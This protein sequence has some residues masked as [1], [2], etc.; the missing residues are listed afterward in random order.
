M[1]AS[2]AAMFLASKCTCAVYVN[3]HVQLLAKNMGD[4]HAQ[5]KR[6][7]LILSAYT[8]LTKQTLLIGEQT[9]PLEPLPFV[10]PKNQIEVIF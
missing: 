1:A 8:Y 7:M 2:P 6:T 4:R 5:I 10:L 9:I 3:I